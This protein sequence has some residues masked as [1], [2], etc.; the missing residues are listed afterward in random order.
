MQFDFSKTSPKDRY[1]L[2]TA[3]VVPRPIALIST[4]SPEGVIN[5]APY[6][7][8]NVFSQDPAIC[9]I[10]IERQSN[11]RLKDSANHIE[12]R[13]EFVV[14]LV[15]ENIADAMNI[16]AIDFPT[17]ISELDQAE[18]TAT[19]STMIETPR[20]AEAPAAL[21]CRLHSAMMIGTGRRLIV[22]EI[23]CVHVEDRIYDPKTQRIVFEE[24][25]PVGRL[26]G[27]YYCRTSDRFELVRESYENLSKDSLKS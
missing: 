4:L 6:S 7:F 15:G 19:A 16:C 22:G 10:G 2:L 25:K 17:E 1:K 27:N 24:Y 3:L 14:N 21:E 12:H 8:F 5:V 26:F 9:V 20:V 13:A 18:L 23:L 11:G